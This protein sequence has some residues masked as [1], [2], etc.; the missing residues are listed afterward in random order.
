MS[1]AS[2]HDESYFYYPEEF[3][4]AELL[5]QNTESHRN[6]LSDESNQNFIQG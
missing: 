4:D 2:E 3:T 5:E 6:L 1:D